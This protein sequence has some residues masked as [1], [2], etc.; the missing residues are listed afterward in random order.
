MKRIFYVLV[1]MVLLMGLYTTTLVARV[2]AN[3]QSH[4][5]LQDENTQNNQ[6]TTTQEASTQET[7]TQERASSDVVEALRLAYLSQTTLNGYD[8]D[9]QNL[10]RSVLLATE[11]L[12]RAPRPEGTL[13]LQNGLNLLPRLVREWPDALADPLISPDDKWLIFNVVD[14]IDDQNRSLE[15]IVWRLLPRDSFESTADFE[16][17]PAFA[18]PLESASQDHF[19]SL[20]SQWLY[21]QSDDTL[22][23]WSMADGN[24]FASIGATVNEI[25]G[26]LHLSEDGHRLTLVND[27]AAIT[28]DTSNLPEILEFPPIPKIADT[29]ALEASQWIVSPTGQH[30]AL[31][32]EDDPTIRVF[33]TETGQLHH[34][35]EQS[36]PPSTALFSPDSQFLVTDDFVADEDKTSEDETSEDELAE[37]ETTESKGIVWVWDLVTGDVYAQIQLL[38]PD[39]VLG[40]RLPIL[41]A[42][43]PQANWLTIRTFGAQTKSGDTFVFAFPPG[44]NPLETTF[45]IED[46]VEQSLS[47]GDSLGI[48]AQ[49]S[50]DDRWLVNHDGCIQKICPKQ[51]RAEVSEWQLPPSRPATRSA[52]QLQLPGLIADSFSP[53]SRWLRTT[54]RGTTSVW[55]VQSERPTEMARVPARAANFSPAGRWLLTTPF[56]G[57][58]QLWSAAIGKQ[59]QTLQHEGVVA[60]MAL[61]HDGQWLA[62]GGYDNVVRLWALDTGAL[63]AELSHDEI[64][65]DELHLG[66]TGIAFSPDGRYLASQNDS[67]DIRLWDMSLLNRA[68]RQLARSQPDSFPLTTDAPITQF[69]ARAAVSL[70]FSADGR[71]LTADGLAWDMTTREQV[72]DNDEVV[73]MEDFLLDAQLAVDGG[74]VWSLAEDTFGETISEVIDPDSPSTTSL[75]S[76]KFHPD[77]TVAAALDINNHVILWDVATGDIIHRLAHPGSIGEIR[78]SASGRWL[79]TDRIDG[80]VTVWDTKTGD[81][82]YTHRHQ[83]WVLSATYADRWLATAGGDGLARVY[84]LETGEELSRFQH[85]VGIQRILFLSGQSQDA[86]SP[87]DTAP[88][89]TAPTDTAPQIITSDGDGFIRLWDWEPDV[90]LAQ[91]CAHLPRNFTELEWAQYFGDEPYRETCEFG[92]R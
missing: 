39:R 44:D 14:E 87:R 26:T 90:L 68:I 20:D 91:A 66:I 73:F 24:T 28:W 84:D 63:R 41:L 36:Q 50:P 43:S 16:I 48:P 11:S 4:A 35:F 40:N 45:T 67:G 15:P 46:A 57:P 17:R 30:V 5:T 49:F 76:T 79:V 81:P 9:N 27:T 59:W 82:M 64:D 61:S 10:I 80:T 12:K 3:T 18:L 13:A 65:V 22:L 1:G 62:T 70:Q 60:A 83:G 56:D 85:H 8:V 21:T 72:M 74:R 55:S 47:S 2:S 34:T 89:D 19:F 54:S 88:R 31:I 71:W 53:D 23:I 33:S 58:L 42:L 25:N 52:F 38:L 86:T 51:F 7:G 77:G 78:F 29:G 6:Q 75:Y 92:G 69:T 32:G 37:G